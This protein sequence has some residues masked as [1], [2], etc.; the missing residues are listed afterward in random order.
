MNFKKLLQYFSPL[1]WGLWLGS[2]PVIPLAF[3]S[4]EIFIRIQS[5]SYLPMVVCFITCLY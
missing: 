3:F 4:A 5:L 1:K 2:L